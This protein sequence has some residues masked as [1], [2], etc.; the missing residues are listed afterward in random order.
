MKPADP[1]SF[2]DR[3]KTAAEAKKALLDKFRPKASVTDPLFAERAAMREAEIDQVRA[4]R[5]QAKADA[6]Q[7]AVDAEA[8]VR[9]TE[10]ADAAIALEAKRGERRE[11]KALTKGEAK[12]KRDARYAAR[13]ARQ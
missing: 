3:L 7:A 11:R 13:K 1:N 2:A 12:A 10:A 8:A 6:K 5:A 9:E 4:D